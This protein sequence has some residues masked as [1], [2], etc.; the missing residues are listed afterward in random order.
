MPDSNDAEPSGTP[1]IPMPAQTLVM[2]AGR[3]RQ[4]LWIDG[5]MPL[6]VGA[7]IQLGKHGDPEPPSDAVVTGIRLWGAAPP[8]ESAT[9]VLDVM[10]IAP[11]ASIDQP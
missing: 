2:D 8:G 3:G 6:P 5:C 1:H 4:L 7:R 9:L 10:L 11:G